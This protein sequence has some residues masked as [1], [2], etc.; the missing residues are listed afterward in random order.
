MSG[1]VSGGMS[2]GMKILAMDTSNWALAVSVMDEGAFIA[3]FN[4]NVPKNHSLRLMPAIELLLEQVEITPKQLAG[5]AVAHGPGSYTGV[6]IGLTTAKTMAWALKLP[7]IGVSSLQVIAQNRVD[8]Q[9]LIVPMFDAR[10]EQVFA[11]MYTYD[12][13]QEMVVPHV[14]DRLLLVQ[15]LI[16]ELQEQDAPCL[17]I[18]EAVKKYRDS[19]EQRLGSKAVFAQ[20]HEFPPSG[21]KL[22]YI[23]WKN[24]ENRTDDVHHMT[25][26]YLQLAEAE[27]NWLANS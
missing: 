18:G 5:I 10:R 27:K 17:F 13:K 22:G 15:D 23:A 26:Q 25:P 9:G 21:N 24:W 7:I 11:G 8:F 1:T 6:R 19:I 3:E 14:A 2:D 20:E 4:T 16:E 12:A